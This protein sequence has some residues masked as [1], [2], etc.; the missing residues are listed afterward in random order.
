M[1]IYIF[2]PNLSIGIRCHDRDTCTLKLINYTTL[3]HRPNTKRKVNK[4]RTL[5][6]DDV[7]TLSS[8][9]A[10]IPISHPLTVQSEVPTAL[11]MVRSFLRMSMWYDVVDIGQTMASSFCNTLPN[12]FHGKISNQVKTM[13]QLKRSIKVGGK[14]VFDLEAIFIRILVIG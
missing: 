14:T 2:I 13:E 4:R 9:L 8:E 5:E 1:D 12:G 3:R 11:S 10:Y 7:E 6:C